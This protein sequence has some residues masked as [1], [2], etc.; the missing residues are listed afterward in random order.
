MRHVLGSL[1]T[2]V[3]RLIGTYISL[4]AGE[5][6]ELD[7]SGWLGGSVERRGGRV[8][9]TDR[10]LVHCPWR[11]W[12]WPSRWPSHERY[13]RT[14]LR[15][16]DIVRVR[17]FQPSRRFRR[18]GAIELILANGQVM[19]LWSVRSRELFAVLKRN[20]A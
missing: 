10:R 14:T 6:V 3:H 1:T 13:K 12:F 15:S 2:L 20:R 16:L 11:P 18:G 19:E 17:D 9:V 7:T 5:S 8:L 4:D